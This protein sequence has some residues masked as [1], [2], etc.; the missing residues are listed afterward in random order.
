M[1]LPGQERLFLV[2]KKLRGDMHY[3][4]GATWCLAQTDAKIYDRGDAS[5]IAV[6]LSGLWCRKSDAA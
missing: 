1:I 5:R 4:N 6:E 3:W 2:M